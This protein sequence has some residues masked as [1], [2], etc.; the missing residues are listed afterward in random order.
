MIKKHFCVASCFWIFCPASHH[1]IGS[2]HE[3]L[4]LEIASTAAQNI[5]VRQRRQGILRVDMMTAIDI[6]KSKLIAFVNIIL[7]YTTLTTSSSS[8]LGECPKLSPGRASLTSNKNIMMYFK[9]TLDD[10]VDLFWVNMQADEV[11]FRALRP[12]EKFSIKTYESH[13]WRV[14]MQDDDATLLLEATAKSGEEIIEIHECIAPASITAK[15]VDSG[16]KQRSWT[17]KDVKASEVRKVLSETFPQCTPQNYLAEA[18]VGKGFFIICASKNVEIAG[19]NILLLRSFT[20]LAKFI[21][22]TEDGPGPRKVIQK[23]VKKRKVRYGHHKPP[24]WKILTSDGNHAISSWADVL[25]GSTNPTGT[26]LV[27]EG[28]VMVW[29]GVAIG[30]EHKISV[31][32]STVILKTLSTK[33]LIFEIHNFLTDVEIGHIINTAKPHMAKSQVSKMNGDE[34]KATSTWRTSSSYFVQRGHSDIVKNIERRTAAVTKVPISHGEGLQIL[35]YAKGEFYKTHHD[36]FAPERYTN[37]KRMMEMIEGG[38]KN[39]LL[40]F[41]W[42][43]SDVEAGGETN[44]PRFGGLSDPYDTK[45]CRQGLSVKPERGKAVL[46]YNLLPSGWP[47]DFSLHSG[48][49]IGKGIKWAVNKWVWNKPF[50]GP[51]DGDEDEKAQNRRVEL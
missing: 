35:R 40:T 26:S 5:A 13:F 51:W 41:F 22:V 32:N 50:P 9:N 33:P 28:G 24:L 20:S 36:F 31:G 7:F 11:Y 30:H 23:Y 14:R 39:R 42:Y 1:P 2:Q 21:T 49:P 34:N 6:R 12:G 3:K 47:D 45:N 17:I 8:E 10:P 25:P 38:A 4:V 29:P 48:C 46:F 15:N 19:R 44:F 16:D 37:D 43:L 27:F 18:D